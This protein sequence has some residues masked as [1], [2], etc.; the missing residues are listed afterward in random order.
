MLYERGQYTNQ[1]RESLLI[2]KHSRN[3]RFNILPKITRDVDKHA[4]AM[5]SEVKVLNCLC[6]TAEAG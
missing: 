1:I 5:L 6:Q 2:L 3:S 4:V